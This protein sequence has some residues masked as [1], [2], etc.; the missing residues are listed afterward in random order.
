MKA[1]NTIIVK[2]RPFLALLGAGLL[3]AFRVFAAA[4]RQF[5]VTL[6]QAHIGNLDV[7]TQL[8]DSY[9]RLPE[10]MRAFYLDARAHFAGNPDAD[11]S[12]PAIVEAARIHGLPLMGGPML[13]DLRADRVTLWLRPAESRPLAIHVARS[14]GTAVGKYPAPAARPGGD[15]RIRLEGLTPSTSYA[16]TVRASDRKLAEGRFTTAPR[17]TDQGVFRL[18]FGS[19]FHKIGLHNPNLFREIRKRE[20]RAML[21]LGD[22]AVDDRENRINLHRSDYLLRDVSRPW[23][24]FAASVPVLASWDDHDYFNDDL[25]GIPGGF[26]AADRDAVRAVW[27]RNWNNPPAD[28][29]RAGIYFNTRMGPVE[30]IMLDTRSCRDNGQRN[31]YGSYLGE[32]QMD[33]LKETLKNSTAPFKVISSGTMWSDYVTK[34]KDSWGSWDTEA[35]EEIYSV[36]ET[37][38]IG[39][40]LLVSGDRHGARAFRI[41]R[42]SGFA[43]HEFEA[44][45][46]GGVPGPPAL[47][48]NCP[49]QL[50]GY[51]GL[52]FIAFGE[53]TFDTAGREPRLTF[54]LIHES[55]GIIEERKFAYRDLVPDENAPVR[56]GDS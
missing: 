49:E 40:V 53:F 41:P 46:L 50:F 10:N 30:V 34:A 45:T 9:G 36:I 2:R 32:R 20:P 5:K 6:D 43:F 19:C 21:L 3:S 35:R 28:D 24:E 47:V 27:H 4:V 31:S 25:S 52:D 8:L 37:E 29:G 23:R 38:N 55:G 17:D 26:K 18:A 14:D 33:W 54:R 48:E 15:Q 39:G 11:F 1:C 13:G 16:Y 7:D 42:P 44:A 56:C 51:H 12:D 22:I